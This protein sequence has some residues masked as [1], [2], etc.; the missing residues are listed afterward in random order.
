[1]SHPIDFQPLSLE[2]QH[3]QQLEVKKSDGIASDGD[4]E[5]QSKLVVSLGRIRLGERKQRTNNGSALTKI[6]SKSGSSEDTDDFL[7]ESQ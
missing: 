7:Q 1:M 6:S 2:D 5:S 3:Q 4:A